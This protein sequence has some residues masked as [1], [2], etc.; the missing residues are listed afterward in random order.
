MKRHTEQP[1]RIKRSWWDTVVHFRIKDE[2]HLLFSA[3]VIVLLGIIVVNT[4]YIIG[5]QNDQNTVASGITNVVS[6]PQKVFTSQLTATSPFYQISVS[7]VTEN[8][9]QDPA[10]TIS[11]D[12]TMLILTLHVKNA[13]NT[14]QVF[15]P[16]QQ[17]YVRSSDGDYAQLHASMYVSKPIQQTTL[18]PGQTVSGQVSFNVP[19]S[20]SRPLLYVDTG[21]GD[22]APVVFDVLH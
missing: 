3:F 9:K 20:Q 10:F 12:E 22:Y 17:L 15:V 2:E 19:K 21:W 6:Q 14:N 11:S 5:K 18:K 13:S 16:S 8:S 4:T 1:K 7:D